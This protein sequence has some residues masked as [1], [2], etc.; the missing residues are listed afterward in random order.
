MQQT[1]CASEFVGCPSSRTMQWTGRAKNVYSVRGTNAP[2]WTLLVHLP[3][4]GA[5]ANAARSQLPL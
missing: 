4:I 2:C 1:A 3:A 5:R